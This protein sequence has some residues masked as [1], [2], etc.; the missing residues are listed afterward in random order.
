MEISAVIHI[1]IGANLPS[2]HGPPRATCAAALSAMDGNGLRVVR[3]SRWYRSAPVPPSAQPWYVNGVAEVET[4]LPPA[5]LLEFLL[6]TEAGFGRR[7]PGP[8]APRTLD[9]DLLAVGDLV[10]GPGEELRLPHPRMHR[11][12]FVLLPL[13]E[14]APDWVHPVLGLRIDRL[15]ADLPPGQI[16]EPIDEEQDDRPDFMGRQ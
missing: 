16:A 6:D 11:R 14:L 4:D 8:D 7:R 9:L 13:A 2:S 3:R 5:G 1:A 15:I 10:T 12:A